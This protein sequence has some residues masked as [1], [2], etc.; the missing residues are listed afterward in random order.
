MRFIPIFFYCLLL[1]FIAQPCFAAKRVALVIGNGK[2]VSAP[3]KNPVN[4]AKDMSAT[5]RALDFEVIKRT[6][7]SKR[8]M[9]QGINI[10]A[11]KLRRSEIG[12]FYYA[13]HGMQINNRNYLIPVKV[14]VNSETD[15]EFESVDVGRVLGKMKQAGNKLNVVVLDACRNNP[16]KR[17]FRTGV[18]G[19]ARMDAPIGTIIAYAT[20]PG[21]IAEDGKGRNG[22]YTKHLLSAITQ[23]GLDIQDMFNDAGI[24]VIQETGNMQIPWMS[25]TPIPRFFLAGEGAPSVQKRQAGNLKVSSEPSDAEVYVNTRYEGVTPLSL[26]ELETGSYTVR[27][28]KADYEPQEKQVLIQSKETAFVSATLQEVVTT[29]T[30][31]V[32]PEPSDAL[33]RILNIAPKYEPGIELGPGRYHVE[34]SRQGYKTVTQWVELAKGEDLE[35]IT[36]LEEN[37]VAVTNTDTEAA[38]TSEK[39]SAAPQKVDKKFLLS[40]SVTKYRD[41]GVTQSQAQK[42]SR[43]NHLIEYYSSFSYFENKHKV[44]SDFIRAF[45]LAESNGDPKALSNEG[46]RGLGQITYPT[47]KMA[48]KELANKNISFRYVSQKRLMNLRSSDLYSP[49]VNILLTCYLVSKYNYKFAGKID[50]VVGALHDGEDTINLETGRLKNLSQDIADLIGRVNGYFIYFLKN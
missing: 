44:N 36:P 1:V 17:S 39:E 40:P 41:I 18:Q 22:M 45:I 23:P 43:F 32:T 28:E 2:Y 37:F 50:L 26:D 25:S 21:S 19:L 27:L 38:E 11:D 20:G 3:L 46:A 48:A 47:G 31:T 15:V 33:V 24:G 42:V 10:F 13:G 7:A 16:F 35:I 12:L 30:L 49:A 5:L 14:E 9:V 34:V 29:G 4:D 6:N 8:E